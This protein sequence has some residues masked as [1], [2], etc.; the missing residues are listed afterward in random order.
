LDDFKNPLGHAHVGPIPVAF[1]GQGAAVH[2][3]VYAGLT[4]V[5]PPAYPK[6]QE[7]VPS[8]FFEEL[9]GQST[10]VQPEVQPDESPL[11]DQVKT[12]FASPPEEPTLQVQ[13]GNPAPF[14]GQDTS[15]QVESQTWVLGFH[16]TVPL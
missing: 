3:P 13:S 10:I 16:V 15:V 4:H 9:G 12:P 5:I 1:T 11:V 2:L 8:G 6:S 14:V 7:H